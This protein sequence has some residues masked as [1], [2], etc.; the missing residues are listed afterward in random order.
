MGVGNYFLT[1]TAFRGLG[2]RLQRLVDVPGLVLC[3]P[4][5]GHDDLSEPGDC[6]RACLVLLRTER[7]LEL[8]SGISSA[9]PLGRT[10]EYLLPGALAQHCEPVPA[11]W[12]ISG[13]YGPRGP[14][15]GV[16]AL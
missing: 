11:V 9:G 8:R 5:V 12:V 13:L 1:A 7:G 15:P 3:G 16:W 6:G 2:R 10:L 4:L 14:V